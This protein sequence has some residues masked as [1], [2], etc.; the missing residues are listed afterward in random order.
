[1]V[2]VP[3]ARRAL[4]GA[5]CASQGYSRKSPFHSKTSREPI[6]GKFPNDFG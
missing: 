6:P 3:K 1:M 5:L 2:R 4:S